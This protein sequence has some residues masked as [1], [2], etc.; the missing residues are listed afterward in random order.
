[1]L[2]GWVGWGTS[3][4]GVR[5]VQVTGVA[6]LTPAEVREAAGVPAQTPLLRVRTAEVADRVAALAPVGEVE[7]T[8]RWPGTLEIAVA[9]RT[10]V[11]AIP[12]PDGV[13]LVDTEGVV[14]HTV[15]EAPLDLP[16]VIVRTP[17]PDDPATR[18]ALTVL[19]ALTPQLRADLEIL[20][21]AG[22]ASIEL[23]LFSG[24]TIRWGDETGS[25]EKARVATALLDQDAEIIDVSAPDVV[26][27]R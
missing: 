20:T 14:F 26:S 5:E 6:I 1:L 21:V 17:G 2:V 10:A 18:A 19:A 9:E 23:S 13:A 3:V 15:P 24:Q 27:L 12:T 22:P 8:R 16:V 11:A 7:V 25:G 4:L